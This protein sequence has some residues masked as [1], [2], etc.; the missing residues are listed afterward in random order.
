MYVHNWYYFATIHN[1]LYSSLISLESSNLN[2]N[3]LSF[4]LTNNYS[5]VIYLFFLV[6]MY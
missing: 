1:T 4:L 2:C 6:L 3:D 5:S